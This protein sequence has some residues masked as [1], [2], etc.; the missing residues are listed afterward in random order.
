MSGI[1]RI[2]CQFYFSKTATKSYFT[3]CEVI[4]FPIDARPP[5]FL[6]PKIQRPPWATRWKHRN[7]LV[8]PLLGS[9][10]YT[11]VVFLTVVNEPTK[12]SPFIQVLQAFSNALLCC[13]YLVSTKPFSQLKSEIYSRICRLVSQ[14]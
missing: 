6:L 12:Q 8:Q 7:I 14:Y 2:S 5:S 3:T 11:P 13:I 1:K 9:F 4:A 10:S